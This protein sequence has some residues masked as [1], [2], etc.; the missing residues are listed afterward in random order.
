MNKVLVV[1]T[2]AIAIANGLS[3]SAP[4][5]RKAA[6]TTFFQMR[7][8]TSTHHSMTLNSSNRDEEIKNLEEQLRLL[9]EEEEADVQE[10]EIMEENSEQ[11]FVVSNNN[12]EEPYAEMLSEQWKESGGS[13]DDRGGIMGTITKG[14]GLIVLLLVIVAFSQVPVGQ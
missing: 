10:S 14:A 5:S 7:S 13:N 6:S 2:I 1:F 8:L 11:S 3:F 4:L 12:L 9:K